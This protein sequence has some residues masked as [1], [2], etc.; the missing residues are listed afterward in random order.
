MI[1][2]KEI[3]V[4]EES[5]GNV[6]QQEVKLFIL[7]NDNGMEVKLTNYG[8]IVTSIIVPD[9]KGNFDDIVLGFDN[10]DQYIAINPYFGATVGRYANRIKN[11]QFQIADSTYF[12]PVNDK[13]HSIHGGLKGFN[14][15][16]WDAEPFQKKD[17]AGIKMHYLSVDGEEGFPGNLDVTVTYTLNQENEL[18]IHFEA[19]TDKSTHINLCNHSYFNLTG[20]KENILNHK[21]K[22]EAENYLEIDEDIIP[23][24]QISPVTGT[25]WDLTKMTEIGENIQK[26]DHDGYHYCYV[27]DKPS[28]YGDWVI[29]VLEPKSGRKMEVFTTQP[30]VQFYTGQSIG[31]KYVGKY[32]LKYSNYDGF[33]LETQHFP[34]SPNHKNFPSTLLLPGEKYDHKVIYKFSTYSS[35]FISSF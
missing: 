20:L 31:E 12:L 18:A 30:G 3:K 19:V 6:D 27:F 25:Y 16:V 35:G 26:L 24:G 4:S 10:L 5:W 14:K 15:Q 34:D 2:N 28:N 8:A 22:I 7:R 29:E 23:T 9:N 17:E 33:C 1:S 11:A 21:I 13:E 32:K